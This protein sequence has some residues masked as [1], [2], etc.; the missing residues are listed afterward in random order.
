VQKQDLVAH[1]YLGLLNRCLIIQWHGVQLEQQKSWYSFLKD[2]C[3]NHLI[4]II[5]NIWH[6]L[7][8]AGEVCAFHFW[9]PFLFIADLCIGGLFSPNL[10]FQTIAET[11]IVIGK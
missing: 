1:S 7:M 2:H 8:L 11:K 3:L 4:L 10:P 9:H 5:M 6:V